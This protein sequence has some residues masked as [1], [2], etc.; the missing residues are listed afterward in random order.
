MADFIVKTQNFVG[1]IEYLL[2]LVYKN[3]IDPSKMPISF[4]IEEFLLYLEKREW[5]DI[6]KAM[7]FLLMIALLMHLKLSRFLPLKEKEDE[8]EKYISIEEITE[9]YEKL[10]VLTNFLE[11]KINFFERVFPR[12]EVESEEEMELDVGV[13]YKIFREIIS[14]IREEKT[15]IHDIPKIEEKMEEISEKLRREKVIKF[16]EIFKNCRRK[17]EVIVYFLAILEL[18]KQK[19]ILVKQ[20]GLFS[21]IY[22]YMVSS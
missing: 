3:E 10:L 1:P 20:K 21:E 12:G 6:S 7:E 4:L 9:E 2:E 11:E 19:R 17:I 5:K 15:V 13:L 16:R 22:I 14:E 8:E 18:I